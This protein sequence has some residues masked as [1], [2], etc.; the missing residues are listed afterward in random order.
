M[1]QPTYRRNKT[2]KISHN[3]LSNI[4]INVLSGELIAPDMF[5]RN[6]QREI[7]GCLHF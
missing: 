2:I 6:F 5:P 7:S 3:T 1:T 4:I